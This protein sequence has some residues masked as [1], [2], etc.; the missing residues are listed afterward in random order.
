ML[1]EVLSLAV[2]IVIGKKNN[3]YGR[4]TD[5]EDEEEEIEDDAV[6]IEDL[7]ELVFLISLFRTCNRTKRKKRRGDEEDEEEE[8][9]DGGVGGAV[10]TRWVIKALKELRGIGRKRRTSSIEEDILSILS[11]YQSNRVSSPL[12]SA[13]SC[14][15]ALASPIRVFFR[16]FLLPR[17]H[18]RRRRLV[19]LLLLRQDHLLFFHSTL[20]V[21]SSIQTLIALALRHA[22]EVRSISGGDVY[23]RVTGGEVGAASSPA[24]KIG[25]LAS[26][27]VSVVPSVAVAGNQ[28]FEGAERDRKKTKNIKHRGRHS[29]NSLSWFCPCYFGESAKTAVCNRTKRKKRRG[30]EEDEEEE[31]EDGGRFRFRFRLIRFTELQF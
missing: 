28:G 20:F 7:A 19:L 24:P 15:L 4:R 21:S 27:K 31:I 23:V 10:H 22:A 5:E 17:A 9:E 18:H 16:L 11:W 13:S 12:R 2:C 30:D 29:F 6:G 1:V 26:P 14:F 8:I 25:P 3:F